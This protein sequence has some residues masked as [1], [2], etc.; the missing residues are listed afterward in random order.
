MTN[1]SRLKLP[2]IM[3]AQ[4]QK[5]VTHNE[6]IRMLDAV[7]QISVKNDTTTVPPATPDEGA[8]YI[9]A[10]GATGSW[11]GRDNQIASWQ[12]GT[13]MYYPPL[14]GWLAWMESQNVLVVWNGSSWQDVVAKG[15]NPVALAGINTVADMTNRLSVKSDAVLF[16][17]DDVTPGNG[18]IR[19]KLNK[20]DPANSA[21]I[22]FQ[23]N[24]SGRAEMGL[25]GDDD[26]HFKV[27]SDGTDWKESIIIDALSGQTGFPQTPSPQNLLVNGDFHINQR[28]F[29]GGVLSAGSY[30]HDRW[31]AG[32]TD[33][34]YSVDSS[35]NVTL[36][37]GNLV[38]IIESPDLAGQVV[39]VSIEKLS[40]GNLVYEI[41]GVTGTFTPASERKGA[42]LTIPTGSTG[43][44][45][46][47]F[48]PASSAVTFSKVKLEPGIAATR[49]YPLDRAL[50]F[51]R[52]LRYFY[53]LD[54][55][56]YAEMFTGRVHS[57]TET[58]AL[59]NLPSV[60][61]AAPA[62]SWG[63][64]FAKWAVNS[65]GSFSYAISVALWTSAIS[66]VTLSL[67]TGTLPDKRAGSIR[68][69]SANGSFIE[70]DAEL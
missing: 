1:T 44:I 42:R 62:V 49:W 17:H 9:I 22:L 68:Q 54:I 28:G 27:S 7:V 23:S 65:G 51:R 39:T 40:G 52:A 14:K 43:N 55:A 45:T 15:L 70:F 34:D 4:A 11:S 50:E 8:S 53:R 3:A 24:W 30:G 2:Y 58:R 6:A 59:V 32:S 31:K 25:A 10:S 12:D 29:A 18:S 35:G 57:P 36:T 56:G 46:L 38:Q 33:A 5:H 66:S 13:W 60:M 48:S 63:G 41:E 21:T 37:S 69:G 16:S 67:T 26:F 64:D 47:K 20:A 19:H 61:R